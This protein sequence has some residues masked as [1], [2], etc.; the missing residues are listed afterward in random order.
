MC[1]SAGR[2][3]VIGPL[4]GAAVFTLLPE[5]LRGSA[6]WRYVLFA[7]IVIV[8][9]VFRPQ[10]LV[11]GNDIRRLLGWRRDRGGAPRMSDAILELANVSK[12][13]GGLSVVEDLELR[14][15]ARLLHRADRP[16]RRRQDH[17]VQ[18]DHRRLS[19]RRRAHPAR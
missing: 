13:F 14:G 7:A 9:M 4:L 6:Q 15:P 2:R 16:E 1:C 3:R 10:G 8:I 11:T 12:H 18:P 5:L 17:G 19:D